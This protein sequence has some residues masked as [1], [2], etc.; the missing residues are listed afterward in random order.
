MNIG[1]CP[2]CGL[3]YNLNV[4][5]KFVDD[6]RQKHFYVCD[7]CKTKFIEGDRE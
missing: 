5:I 1:F 7:V 2:K 6:D 4:K 3:L